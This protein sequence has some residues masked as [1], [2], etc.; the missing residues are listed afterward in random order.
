[1]PNIFPV[2][3]LQATSFE[4]TMSLLINYFFAYQVIIMY[5]K[6]CCMQLITG[7]IY[8]GMWSKI[9]QEMPL[10]ELQ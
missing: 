8:G 6:I 2:C 10:K 5:F 4:N 9:Y 7:L 1:M 3:A